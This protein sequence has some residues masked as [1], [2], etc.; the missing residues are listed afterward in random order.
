MNFEN[1]T[2]RSRGFVQSAQTLAVREGHQQLTPE[3]LLKV[4]L[5]DKEGLAVGL[6]RDAGGDP[7]AA[8]TKAEATLARLP[9]VEGGGAGQVYPA[10]E[11]IKYF[12]QLE[13]LANKVGDSIVTTDRMLQALALQQGTGSTKALMDAGVT[14]KNLEKAID[15]LRKGHSADSATSENYYDAI[16]KYTG[17]LTAAAGEGKIDPVIGREEEIRRTMQVLSRRTKNNP[18]LI[19]EPGVGK[20]AIVEGLAQRIVNGD[21][22]EGL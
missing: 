16:K 3:H 9:K 12:E 1:Y 7:D 14:A 22:P 15:L 17:D 21:V 19:G 18:V 5:E 2:E 4:L 13:E 11:L 8:R 20:T 6:I 10:Q